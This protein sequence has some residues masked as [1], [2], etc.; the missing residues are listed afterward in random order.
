MVLFYKTDCILLNLSNILG[1][2]KCDYFCRVV[3]KRKK[4]ERTE[5]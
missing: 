1:L 5:I 2:G 4:E 3:P